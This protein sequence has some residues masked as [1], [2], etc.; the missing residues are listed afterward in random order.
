MRAIIPPLALMALLVGFAGWNTNIIEKHTNQC[1]IGI[2]D[3]IHFADADDWPAV[4]A[5]LSASHTRWQNSRSYLRITVTHS[6]IDAADSMYCRALSFAETEDLTEF[7]AETAGLRT[8]LLRLA[9]NEQFRLE[10][11][12]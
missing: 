4:K 5:A 11:I 10:N 12:F 1:L 8:Q 7:Q 2:E 9:E 6:T 3:A